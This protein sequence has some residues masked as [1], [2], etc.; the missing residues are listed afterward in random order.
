MQRGPQVE[1]A[2]SSPCAIVAPLVLCLL[3]LLRE[4]FTFIIYV[5]QLLLQH[6]S[7]KKLLSL[8]CWKMM[9]SPA[10]YPP[11]CYIFWQ[12]WCCWV[13]CLNL[14]PQSRVITQRPDTTD[15]S[16]SEAPT[17]S[18]N[19]TA[20][21]RGWEFVKSLLLW[22]RGCNTVQETMFLKACG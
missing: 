10:W 22:S 21:S 3:R 7:F 15:K 19:Q 5:L 14:G 1:A 13:A 6:F 16:V 2:Q 17:T 9:H 11:R 18:S 20:S 12:R 8:P 4:C